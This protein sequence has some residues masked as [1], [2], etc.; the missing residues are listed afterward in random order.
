MSKDPIFGGDTGDN[1]IMEDKIRKF[2][3]SRLL[4]LLRPSGPSG[5][6]PGISGVLEGMRDRVSKNPVDKV[7]GLAYL[8]YTK[9]IPAYYET[10]SEEDAWTALVCVMPESIRMQMLLNYSAPG[11]GYKVWRES[12]R[13]V[14]NMPEIAMPPLSHRVDWSEEIDA[15][16]FQG[17]CIYSSYI[18]GLTEGSRC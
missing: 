5:G 7:V 2:L 15:D 9:E 17:L 10:Q 16:W 18:E 8:L 3:L 6:F 12:W 1:K 13:Q 14:M 11:N 4:Y